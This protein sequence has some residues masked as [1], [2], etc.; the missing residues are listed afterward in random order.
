MTKDELKKRR[1]R[2]GMTQDEFASKVG[3]T[4]TSISRYETGLIKIPG[5]MDLAL[6]ALEKRQ[7]ENLKQPIGESR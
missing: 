1:E 6:E 3:V 2:L 5:Y 4:A 7:I